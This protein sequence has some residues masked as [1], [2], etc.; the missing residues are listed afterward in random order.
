MNI[1]VL[2]LKNNRLKKLKTQKKNLK[3]EINLSHKKKFKHK[4]KNKK[5]IWKILPNNYTHSKENCLR[6]R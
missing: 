4:L 3:K 6:I 5:P 1:K 2:P